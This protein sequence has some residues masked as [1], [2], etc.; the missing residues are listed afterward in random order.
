VSGG[1]KIHG[2]LLKKEFKKFSL[3]KPA[4]KDL[5][6]KFELSAK[7]RVLQKKRRRGIE[8][9]TGIQEKMW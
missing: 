5:L 8:E 1:E 6:Q 3:E 9:K 4:V 7:A 2:V